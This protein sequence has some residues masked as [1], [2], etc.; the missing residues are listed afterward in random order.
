MVR[1]GR[2]V[3]DYF[4]AFGYWSDEDFK[5]GTPFDG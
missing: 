1:F 2:E 4:F 5:P 3:C